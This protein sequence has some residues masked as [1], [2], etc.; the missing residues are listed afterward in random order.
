MEA[1]VRD[2]RA[3]DRLLHARRQPAHAVLDE[4]RRERLPRAAAGADG[5]RGHDGALLLGRM[6]GTSRTTTGPTASRRTSTRHGSAS[7]PKEGRRPAPPLPTSGSPAAGP[8]VNGGARETTHPPRRRRRPRGRDRPGGE[9]RRREPIVPAGPRGEL[10]RPQRRVPVPHP[11]DA[12]LVG[13]E[14]EP[15]HRPGLADRLP[16][17]ADAGDLAQLHRLRQS[18]RRP[19][20]GRG[21]EG[22]P[23]RRG[24]LRPQGVRHHT[25]DR[26]EAARLARRRRRRPDP[27]ERE[28]AAEPARAA[29]RHV[30]ERGHG[31]RSRPQARVPLAR[32][33]RLRRE[34]EHGRVGHLRDRRAASG[35]DAGAR[36]RAGA[37][38][39]HDDVRQ[40]LQ[41]ALDRRARAGVDAAVDVGRPPDLGHRPARPAQPEGAPRPDRHAPQRRDHGL[42]ARRPGRLGRRRLGLG[43]RRDPRLLDEGPALRPG[44]RRAAG[45]D[46]RRPGSLR[47]RRDR[48]VG[49][50]VAVLPQLVAPGR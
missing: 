17:D 25:A 18:A 36:L 1:P 23:L 28:H 45:G 9:R 33:A 15:D 48:R 3:G 47:G 49:G 30:G 24:P 10:V 2:E 7:S 26:A 43:P 14:R 22:R 5:A 38:R 8:T 44:P 19:A 27:P 20:R 21:D 37:G 16:R 13:R 32:P 6:A 11:D 29:R 12:A 35:P 50:A 31:R 41:V 40:R 34:H 42:R 39:P 4:V 46:G